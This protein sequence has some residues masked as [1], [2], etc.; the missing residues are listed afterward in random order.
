MLKTLEAHLRGLF[1]QPARIGAADPSEHDLQLATAVLLVE[2]M[3]SDADFA[4][5]E[6]TAIVNALRDKFALDSDE[7]AR[8]IELAESRSETAFDF[9]HFTSM[10]NK[11]FSLKQKVRVI[12]YLWRVAYAD[13]HVNDYEQHVMRKIADLLYIPHGDYIAAKERAKITG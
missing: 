9:Q 7:T 4:A 5:A 12:E 2:V 1:G 13:G 6:R 10:L 3:R 8:L 11:G